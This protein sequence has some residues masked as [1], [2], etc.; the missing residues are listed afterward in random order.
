MKKLFIL[1]LITIFAINCYGQNLPKKAPRFSEK[2][3]VDKYPYYKFNL[4]SIKNLRHIGW[5][6]ANQF[7]LLSYESKSDNVM[8]LYLYS[9]NNN[10][11]SD[12]LKKVTNKP[13]IRFYDNEKDYYDATFFNIAN[14]GGSRVVELKEWNA[15]LVLLH[16]NYGCGVKKLDRYSFIIPI[17]FIPQENG[18]YEISAFEPHN[19]KPDWYYVV[20]GMGDGIKYDK[21]RDEYSLGFYKG[22]QETNE[23]FRLYFTKNNNNVLISNNNIYE[24]STV[25]WNKG[26]G[27][28]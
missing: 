25:Y 11:P 27:E 6:I 26:I 21:N 23:E 20:K 22:Y 7:Y 3:L 1:S 14:G 15:Y 24:S 9:Q 13:I 18:Q 19:F 28:V 5:A 4:D 17:F 12:P 16:V 8:D 10:D 2:P